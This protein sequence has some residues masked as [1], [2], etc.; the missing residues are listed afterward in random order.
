MRK[1][2]SIAVPSYN[3]E[4][5]LPDTLASYVA[6]IVDDRLEVLI[7][8]DGST[9]STPVLANEFV[10]MYPQIF[11]LVIQA[12]IGDS[13]PAEQLAV[14]G[15]LIGSQLCPAFSACP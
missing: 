14:Q 9:D 6:G 1:V 4:A 5:Y 12:E 8:N 10:K 3:V 15:N 7:G 13:C 11:R 2:L